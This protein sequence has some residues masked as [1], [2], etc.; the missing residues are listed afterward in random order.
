MSYGKGSMKGKIASD[1]FCFDKEQ[2]HC[3]DQGFEFGVA[4]ST[5]QKYNNGILG[6]AP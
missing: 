1:K 4:N 5:V 3:I 2:N 6:L